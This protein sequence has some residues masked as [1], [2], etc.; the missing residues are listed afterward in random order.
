MKKLLSI[1][2]VFPFIISCS[3]NEHVSLYE[4][5][6]NRAKLD[7]SSEKDLASIDNDLISFG[8]YKPMVKIDFPM[9]SKFVNPF[10]DNKPSYFNRN[11][12]KN[13]VVTNE[14][15]KTV[16]RYQIL[17]NNYKTLSDAKNYLVSKGYSLRDEVIL[18]EYHSG[19]FNDPLF[20]FDDNY[21]IVYDLV[22]DVTF[23]NNNAYLTLK[24]SKIK[25]FEGNIIRLI[26]CDDFSIGTAYANNEMVIKNI[27]PETFYMDIISKGYQY[28]HLEEGLYVNSDY[29]ISKNDDCYL[30]EP[31]DEDQVSIRIVP[32]DSEI[33]Y[34][35][36][37]LDPDYSFIDNR[38]VFS[39]V[40]HCFILNK[41]GGND[42]Y[43]TMLD[44]QNFRYALLSILERDSYNLIAKNHNSVLP[45]RSS[46]SKWIIPS[47]DNKKSYYNSIIDC[48]LDG[49]AK[50]KE[51]AGKI[52]KIED[53]I[54]INTIFTPN[55]E[56]FK[57]LDKAI[58]DV[59][60]DKVTLK[61]I[62]LH[63][64]FIAMAGSDYFSFNFYNDISTDFSN[65]YSPY[66]GLREIINRL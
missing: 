29:N 1:I 56:S 59:F 13:I 26:C 9:M 19:I 16:D 60:K 18:D 42:S 62:V 57:Y 47:L 14:Y 58:K 54:E 7:F 46:I 34:R 52:K 66:F 53:K 5:F 30:M 23:N 36:V 15:I 33:D 22:R 25:D 17:D 28:P 6:I 44:D 51:Y 3:N 4:D 63:N 40:S 2:C 35:F 31:F 43:K 50:A 38:Y 41:D 37:D 64:D 11:V 65:Y 49:I 21:N 10:S 61:Q 48:D 32:I 12:F 55:S 27:N 8:A 20:H 24:D 45:I 39:S